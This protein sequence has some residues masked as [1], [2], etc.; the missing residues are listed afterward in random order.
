MKYRQLSKNTHV[1]FTSFFFFRC[2]SRRSGRSSRLFVIFS[3][4]R[5]V[6]RK[7]TSICRAG[8]SP[9]SQRRRRRPNLV[10]EAVASSNDGWVEPNGWT[11][12]T[13]EKKRREP[14]LK[15]EKK[16][17][18]RVHEL[19][20]WP[21]FAAPAGLVFGTKNQRSRVWDGS[22]CTKAD[23][24]VGSLSQYYHIVLS[25]LVLVDLLRIILFHSSSS[26]RVDIVGRFYWL[27][28]Y[29]NI[30]WKDRNLYCSL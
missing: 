18:I 11:W 27:A 15:E 8:R 17:P 29:I 23:H 24:Q 1:W 4:G 3:S 6:Q 28:Y 12:W 10:M 22:I 16:D 5:R 30:Y 20:W 14:H 26:I 9:N 25:S 7:S 2:S 21:S 13:K 19:I